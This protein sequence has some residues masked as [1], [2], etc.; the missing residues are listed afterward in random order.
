MTE[1]ALPI[2]A[3]LTMK[4]GAVRGRVVDPSG[5]VRTFWPL[6]RC[7]EEEEIAELAPGQSAG[8]WITLLRGAEGSLFAAPGA[9]RVVV[10]VEWSLGEARIHLSGETSVMISPA[11]NEAHAEAAL[12]V[13]ASPDALLTL[14]IGGDHLEEGIEAIHAALDSP[15][16]QPHY[17]YIEAKRIGKRFGD[18]E[19]DIDAASELLTPETVVTPRE[20][21]KAVDLLE[22]DEAIAGSD[23]GQELIDV[24]G[25]RAEG[26]P[27]AEKRGSGRG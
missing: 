1:Q 17:A 25:A 18:R 16:L 19:A 2:P 11:E 20:A 10:E 27:V 13:I 7:I 5:T 3:N 15:V 26:A 22:S 4:G 24:L 23:R 21:Q 6:V 8:D 12:K 14:V 9:H